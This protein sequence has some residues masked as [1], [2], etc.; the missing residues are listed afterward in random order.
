MSIQLYKKHF[1]VSKKTAPNF[2]G[3]HWT[4]EASRYYEQSVEVKKEKVTGTFPEGYCWQTMLCIADDLGQAAVLP[5][6]KH[7]RES[8]VELGW[9][10]IWIR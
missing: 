10:K 4:S 5:D 2:S 8:R 7:H 9:D 6:A 1:V 3:S